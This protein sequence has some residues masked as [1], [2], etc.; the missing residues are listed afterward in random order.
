[1]KAIDNEFCNNLIKLANESIKTTVPY[2]TYKAEGKEM[3]DVWKLLIELSENT[4][5]LNKELE[6]KPKTIEKI[7]Y[8][9]K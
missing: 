4:I 9:K 2:R 6:D 3:I 5:K 8:R 1:M 7:I